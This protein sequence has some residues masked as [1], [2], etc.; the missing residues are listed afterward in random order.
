MNNKN[1]LSTLK[2]HVKFA[3]IGAGIAGLAAARTLEL[4]NVK[5]YVLIEG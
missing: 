5:D 4:A 1:V 2:K 3:I